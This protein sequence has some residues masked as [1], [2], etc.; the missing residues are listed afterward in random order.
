[1]KTNASKINSLKSENQE[2][3]LKINSLECQQKEKDSK[4]TSVLTENQSLKEA[5]VTNER[6]LK[7]KSNKINSLENEMR[8][9]RTSS[10]KQIQ[11]L[12]TLNHDKNTLEQNKMQAS[13]EIERLK[14]SNVDLEQ[15]LKSKE[16]TTTSLNGENKNL[17][18]ANQFII[19]MM[20]TQKSLLQ[21]R[22]NEMELLRQN[23]ERQLQDEKKRIEV[24]EQENRALKQ[25]R[26][27]DQT[28]T[29]STSLLNNNR[30]NPTNVESNHDGDVDD[31]QN[32]INY[33]SDLNNTEESD[34]GEDNDINYDTPSEDEKT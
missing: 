32:D 4:R 15:L 3:K 7:E 20:D 16:D 21:A 14:A 34:D 1:M 25:E 17:S 33:D 11:K 10:L 31:A 30:I 18:T 22:T 24:L 6:Q 28:N 19:E 23:M 27:Q 5:K 13:L 2:L 29:Q 9:Y 26:A 12:E 8:T